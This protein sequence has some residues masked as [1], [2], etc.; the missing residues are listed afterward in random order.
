MIFLFALFSFAQSVLVDDA[1][2]VKVMGSYLNQSANGQ[3][4]FFGFDTA[5]DEILTL[6]SFST[7]YG[8]NVT[9]KFSGVAKQPAYRYDQNG[10]WQAWNFY[11]TYFD[12]CV[13]QFNY[14]ADDFTWSLQ[15][16][17]AGTQKRLP[18][19]FVVKKQDS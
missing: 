7:Y 12:S 11:T 1:H 10:F 9:I 19:G 18:V 13:A 16:T 6:N 4:I 8:C 15:D 2:S 3:Q 17:L 14:E 5:S